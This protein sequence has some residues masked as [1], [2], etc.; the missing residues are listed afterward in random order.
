MKR[1]IVIIC[2]IISVQVNA[3]FKEATL[4]ASGLTCS[5]CSKAIYKAL[6]AIDFVSNVKSDIDNSA[7]VIQFKENA[8][9]NFDALE[10]AVTN[11]GF[12]VANL[13]VLTTFSNVSI[14]K[15]A[16]IVMQGKTFHFLNAPATIL[17]GEKEITIVDKNFTSAKTFKKVS[18]STSM[19]C[20]ESGLMNG[21]RVYHVTI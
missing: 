16:H 12:S 1:I 6:I 11:A 13:K 19:K 18:Q 3:Q 17:N 5:M 10:K 2:L 9:I 20:V 4:Q 21:Q 15:D 7:F 8:I 14:K